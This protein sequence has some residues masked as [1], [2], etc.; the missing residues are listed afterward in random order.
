MLLSSYPETVDKLNIDKLMNELI[1]RNDARRNA[2]SMYVVQHAISVIG[3]DLYNTPCPGKKE[4]G[5]F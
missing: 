2:F 3:I 4:A 5:V 1:I